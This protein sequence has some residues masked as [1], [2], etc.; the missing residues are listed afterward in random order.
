[1]GK[2]RPEIM[3][4][5]QGLKIKITTKTNLKTIVKEFNVGAITLDGPCKE[6]ENPGGLP[7]PG[8]VHYINNWEGRKLVTKIFGKNVVVSSIEFTHNIGFVQ[9]YYAEGGITGSRTFRK[10]HM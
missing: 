4:E 7:L 5:V 6:F 3:I 8:K 9:T 2:Q 1:M 10:N